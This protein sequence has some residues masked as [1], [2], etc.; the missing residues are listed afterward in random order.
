[1]C[2]QVNLVVDTGNI[3][4]T[5]AG[6]MWKMMMLGSPN[7]PKIEIVQG[8]SQIVHKGIYLVVGEHDV[9]SEAIPK[10]SSIQVLKP[11][12]YLKGGEEDI[13]SPKE[14]TPGFSC[15]TAAFETMEFQ[16]PFDPKKAAVVASYFDNGAKQ[17]DIQDQ[18]YLQAVFKAAYEYLLFDRPFNKI[19][20][21]LVELDKYLDHL[22]R[23][24]M[25]VSRSLRTVQAVDGGKVRRIAF[26]NIAQEEAPWATKIASTVYDDVVTY[27]GVR[28]G[29]TYNLFS[30]S[31]RVHEYVDG[32]GRPFNLQAHL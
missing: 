28:D 18:A 23:V 21:E 15:I 11:V 8:I 4:Q 32:A 17:I 6:A 29:V 16:W 22:K 12:E 20:Y 14:Y 1:M 27:S 5:I 24:K 2:T 9:V 30:R 25:L 10:G 13:D 7:P 3:D 26:I 31:K 19:E